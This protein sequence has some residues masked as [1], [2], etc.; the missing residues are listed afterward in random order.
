MDQIGG[1]AAPGNEKPICVLLLTSV[2]QW[3][4]LWGRPSTLHLSI[5]PPVHSSR[6]RWLPSS[7]AHISADNVTGLFSHS[8]TLGGS[9]MT[10]QS[11]QIARRW[12]V[13]LAVASKH[14]CWAIFLW[15]QFLGL[16]SVF[17]LRWTP[18][19]VSTPTQWAQMWEDL[20][21]PA[22]CA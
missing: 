9:R 10:T 15:V 3:E 21:L 13:S 12:L 2:T 19:N 16:I 17:L 5:L 4:T 14:Q 6:Q 7:Y 20:A 8:D 11:S 22:G 18:G 1:G